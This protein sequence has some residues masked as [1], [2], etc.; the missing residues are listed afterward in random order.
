MCQYK[1]DAF[2]VFLAD[3]PSH[4]QQF[5]VVGLNSDAGFTCTPLGTTTAR[6]LPGAATCPWRF[7]P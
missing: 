5:G 7:P 3:T 2:P 6:A 1:K 4:M